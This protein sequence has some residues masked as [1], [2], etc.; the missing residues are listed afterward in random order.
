MYKT[1]A[2]SMGIEVKLY[3]LLVRD[4]APP[5]AHTVLRP[6]PLHFIFPKKSKQKHDLVDVSGEIFVTVCNCE[7][8]P[9][10]SLGVLQINWIKVFSRNFCP[11]DF[12]E[13]NDSHI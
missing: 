6:C 4:L 10:S 8:F 3:N 1:L 2:V 5:V 11:V 13:T 7:M 12:V 9:H